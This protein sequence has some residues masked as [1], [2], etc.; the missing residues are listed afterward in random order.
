ME[1]IPMTKSGYEKLKDEVKNLKVVERPAVM[2]AIAEARALGDLSENAEYSSAREKQGFIEGRIIELEDK[3][4]RA[5]IIDISKLA[6]DKVKFGATVKLLDD[7]TE[8]EVIYQIV[9]DH[10]S[11]IANGKISL[12]SPLAKG[13]IGKE[14]GDIAEIHT[15]K[16]IKTY[17]VLSVEF[18]E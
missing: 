18:V 6:G 17:E 13:L 15:P 5:E 4:A 14:V 3:I 2:E 1:K 10:E 11:D 8:E 7:E 12:L 9:G 16:G